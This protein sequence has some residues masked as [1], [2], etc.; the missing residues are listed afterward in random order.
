[1]KTK[2]ADLNVLYGVSNNENTLFDEDGY[3]YDISINLHDEPLKRTK[4]EAE[5]LLKSLKESGKIS[6]DDQNELH[7]IQVE[8][9]AIIKRLS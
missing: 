8:F 1:M 5:D 6:I 4:E 7:V 3:M 9:V 2:Q